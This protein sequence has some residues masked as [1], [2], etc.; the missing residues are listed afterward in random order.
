MK[1]LSGR[2]LVVLALPALLAG[3]TVNAQWVQTGGPRAASS[4]DAL[5]EVANGSGGHNLLVGDY[6]G[7]ILISTNGG[8]GW[9]IDTWLG[10]SV[11]TFFATS[12]STIFVGTISAG[13]FS[14]TDGGVTW[15]ASNAGR[16]NGLMSSLSTVA[17]QSGD[18]LAFASSFLDTLYVSKKS[19]GQ[20]SAWS[21]SHA[22]LNTRN[23][24]SHVIVAGSRLFAGTYTDGVFVSTD[25]G[26]T[27]S[28]SSTGLTNHL[29]YDL[30]SLDTVIFAGT[31]GGGIFRSTD[32]GASWT[33]ANNGLTNLSVNRVLPAGN[34]LYAGSAEGG[35]FVSTDR[36]AS[37]TSWAIPGVLTAVEE[38]CAS[39]DSMLYAGTEADGVFKSPRTASSW[40]SASSGLNFLYTGVRGILVRGSTVFAGDPNGSG[41]YASGDH[42][43]SWSRRPLNSS[44]EYQVYSTAANS[45]TLFAGTV[46]GPCR[47]TDNG[48]TWASDTSGIGAL[49]VLSLA[50]SD[51][52]AVAGTQGFSLYISTNNGASW[53]QK[54]NGL[55]SPTVYSLAIAGGMLFAGTSSGGFFQSSDRGNNW[56]PC[57]PGVTN[58]VGRALFYDGTRLYGGTYAGVF[59]STN[60]GSSWQIDTL[61]MGAASVR[62]IFGDGA[63][64]YVGTLNTGVFQSPYGGTQWTSRNTGLSDLGVFSFGII[65]D[66]L[67]AG[68]ASSGV[69][70]CPRSSL[71]AVSPAP[72]PAP[73]TM[74][75]AQNF[76]N[77]FNPSTTIRYGLPARANT[78]LTVFNALGQQIATPV[79]ASEEA[80][81][82]EVTF[83]GSQ[84]ASGVYFYRL[85]A[86]GLVLTRKLLLLR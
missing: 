6:S 9:T 46:A 79:N 39:S 67:F 5:T 24:V 76:P 62:T 25:K 31:A 1:S 54:S 43:N 11:Y 14:S 10:S 15:A 7:D 70:K 16:S 27:W 60:M 40:T 3:G 49:L 44:G 53:V 78:V 26:A 52:I 84:L 71:T 65:G 37:W 36:G 45:T 63:N 86:G 21:S 8:A 41:L 73:S 28:Q 56:L 85:Q 19:A 61:G 64:I 32:L 29:V 47:S 38:L 75:L 69:W 50:V 23:A 2:N 83:D 74:T 35:V 57:G 48:A 33:T 55:T 20:W 34:T 30:A 22:G 12:G 51:S 17:L 66:T 72:S 81:Y 13:V 80:G 77:P 18:S 58:P 68:T 42:G 59:V 4:I 82:H